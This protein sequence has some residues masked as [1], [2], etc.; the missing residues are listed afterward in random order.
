MVNI[1]CQ[2]RLEK[3]V[4]Q[5]DQNLQLTYDTGFEAGWREALL[6]KCHVKPALSLFILLT[7]VRQIFLR[8]KIGGAVFED[9]TAVIETAEEGEEQCKNTKQEKKLSKS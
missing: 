4:C 6:W 2:K 8:A 9:L 1:E 3:Q 5:P 7:K